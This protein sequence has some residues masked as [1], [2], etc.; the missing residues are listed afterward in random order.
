MLARFE[1]MGLDL[2]EFI[3]ALLRLPSQTFRIN[4]LKGT[5]GEVLEALSDLEP[6]PCPWSNLVFRVK[7]RRKIGNLLEHF[8]GLIYAQDSS[9]SIPV[10]VLDPRPGETVLDMAAAPGSKSTQIAAA[11][12]N[13]GLLVSNDMSVSRIPSLTGNL[14]RSGVLNVVVTQLAGQSYGYLMPGQFDRILLD[15]PCSSE[16]TLSRSLRVLEVWTENS[17]SR[18]AAIQR[19][20]ILSAYYSLKPGGVMVYSTC[21]FAPEE[22]E[23]VVSHLLEKFPDTV[24][25]P[26]SFEGLN[27]RPGFDS[28]RGSEFHPAVKNIMRLFPHEH[29]GEGFCVTK[30]R[31]P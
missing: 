20:M 7:G 27:S 8:L 25:E 17:I 19:A 2:E 30:I 3:P 18:L 24:V 22:N 10:A 6:E 13:T 28:W 9:S 29:D 11:M 1:E 14:D 23:G 26:V 5:R 4:T 31:K 16:G 12:E 15:A 21:T